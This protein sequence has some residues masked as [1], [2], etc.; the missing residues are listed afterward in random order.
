MD[1]SFDIGKLEQHT[2]QL[3]VNGMVWLDH[4][5]KIRHANDSA[6]RI[7]GYTYDELTSMTIMDIDIDTD[8]EILEKQIASIISEKGS[9]NFES[10]LTDKK[11]KKIPVEVTAFH[12]HYEKM[13][14][15]CGFFHDISLRK[16]FQ[17]KAK[18]SEERVRAIFNNHFQ[19]T[20]LLDTNGRL[21][22]ANQTALKLLDLKEDELTGIFFWDAPWFAH[23]KKLQDD[24]QRYVNQAVKGNFVRA[25]FELQDKTGKT[26]VFDNSFK[27]VRDE[28]GVVQF[29]VPEARDIT[30]IRKAERKLKKAYDELEKLKDRLQDENLYLKEELRG[31]K[32]P[33][34]LVGQSLAFKNVLFQIEQ[35]AQTNATVL[36]LGE[37]GTGKELVAHTIHDLSSRR[38]QPLVKLNCAAI[39]ASL[40]ESELFGHEKGSFTGAHARKAGRFELADKGTIFLDEIGELPIDLQ[41]KLLRVLQENE[42]ERIGGTRTLKVD[43]R[44][45]AA[46]NRDLKAMIKEK[47]FREDL[48]YRLHVFPV[49][50]PPLRER[51]E[52]IVFLSNFLIKQI[53]KRIGKAIT[54][55]SESAIKKLMN[56]HWPGNVR[57]LENILERAAVLSQHNTLEIGDWFQT[58]RNESLEISEW[59]TLDELQRRHIIRVLKKTRG[60]IRGGN[61][62][63]QILGL[64]PTTLEYRMK[65][66]GIIKSKIL[67]TL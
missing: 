54:G 53:S 56:Y 17:A 16:K 40:V 15:F 20:G 5:K 1:K 29:V 48:Y 64:K 10:V 38:N 34:N 2:V 8:P 65:I 26:Y 18:E 62:A 32:K 61:G 66:L 30:E 44:I 57:E 11:N 13:D 7:L 60:L 58:D 46:T 52:D 59:L 43:I 31:S 12:I 6:C 9:Y 41:V 23:S 55:I 19:L 51:S 36:I 50:I 25:E 21:L 14:L 24:V 47:S 35:V 42:F 39:P 67:E 27:P 49:N 22:M 63:A 37:T 45:I 3:A 4:E 33:I 28:K